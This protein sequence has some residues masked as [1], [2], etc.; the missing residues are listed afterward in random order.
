[1]LHQISHAEAHLAPTLPKWRL[2]PFGVNCVAWVVLV[3]ANAVDVLASRYAFSLGVSELNPL[4]ARLLD[5][6]GIAGLVVVKAV[7]LAALL[8]L[9]PR[10]NGKLRLL[11][12]FTCIVYVTVVVYHFISLS[13]I[14]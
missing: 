1:M 8:V 11:L 14:G 4:V 10:M 2:T 9:L 13:V 12:V 3:A 5:A 7:F 6:Y